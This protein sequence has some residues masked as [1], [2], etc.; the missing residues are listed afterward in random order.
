MAYA[1]QKVRVISRITGYDGE[2]L[3]GDVVGLSVVLDVFDPTGVKVVDSQGMAW[4][5]VGN[6]NGPYWYFD[7]TT[8]ANPP[9]K[10]KTEVH[11]TG[12]PDD[13]DA[14]DFGSIKLN[15]RPSGTGG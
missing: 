5:P 13:I 12:G 2:T 11:A 3:T 9:A 10:Y 7:W 4:H 14:F 15:K 1:G 6:V 8:G